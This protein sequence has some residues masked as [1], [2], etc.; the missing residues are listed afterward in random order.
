M[1][2]GRLAVGHVQAA[3]LRDHRAPATLALHELLR[4]LTREHA[5]RYEAELASRR[6][7]AQRSSATT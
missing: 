3:R 5:Q 7:R 4:E 2:A 1:E 6:P